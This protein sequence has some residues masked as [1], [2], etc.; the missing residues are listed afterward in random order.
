MCGVLFVL[1]RLTTTQIRVVCGFIVNV[2]S[3]FD[4][5]LFVCLHST[6]ICKVSFS[7]CTLI[8]P[9]YSPLSRPKGIHLRL[10]VKLVQRVGLLVART[11]YTINHSVYYMLFCTQT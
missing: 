4:R 3:K 8:P 6:D 11:M 5:I 9:F 1:V 2:R 10:R 7:L